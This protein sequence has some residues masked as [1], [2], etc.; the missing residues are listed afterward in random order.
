MEEYTDHKYTAQIITKYTHHFPDLY[1]RLILHVFELGINGIKPYIFFWSSVFLQHHVCKIHPYFGCRNALIFIAKC[2]S[3]V[4][5]QHYFSIL[6]F[7][8]IF[9]ASS[10]ELLWIMFL[11]IFLHMFFGA[12]VCQIYLP[13][14]KQV[15][16]YT[17]V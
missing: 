1:N 16:V 12:H 7:M 8:D 10:L 11:W 3:I 9:V 4:W 13:G 2:Y 6:P 5:I 15:I 14:V 17:Y